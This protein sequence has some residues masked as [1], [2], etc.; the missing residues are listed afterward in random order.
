MGRLAV[1]PGQNFDPATY[2]APRSVNAMFTLISSGVLAEPEGIALVI[3]V[4][5]V[6]R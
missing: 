3:H 5:L 2:Q 4:P 6:R 1:V